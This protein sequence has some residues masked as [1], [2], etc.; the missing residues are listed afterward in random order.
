MTMVPITSRKANGAG[1]AHLD[2]KTGDVYDQAGDRIGRSEPS[3]TLTMKLSGFLA[4]VTSGRRLLDLTPADVDTGAA[5]GELIVPDQDPVADLVSP[6]EFAPQIIG[7]RFFEDPNDAAKETLPTGAPAGSQVPTANLTPVKTPYECLQY[8]V[9]ADVPHSFAANADFDILKG[10]A[11]RLGL[12]LRL[13]RERRVAALVLTAGNWASNNVVTLAAG[14][15]WN[16]GASADPLS[17]IYALLA[18]S[19]LPI[20]DIVMS[21]AVAP[22]WLTSNAATPTRMQNFLMALDGVN[23]GREQFPRVTFAKMKTIASGVPSYI[24]G[25]ATSAN[26]VFLRSPRTKLALSSSRTFRHVGEAPD[27]SANGYLVREYFSTRHGGRGATGLVVVANDA[28]K[29]LNN[30]VGGLLVGA[31][32]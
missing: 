30:T 29:I 11:Y 4:D 12:L 25:N 15:K 1:P 31:L 26:V 24:W 9:A 17:D 21:E 14:A 18:K 32:Q 23:G 8:G 5:V 16:G 10:T 2:P 6:F 27:G 19:S 13:A 3:P 20:T 22:F 28:E 7:T